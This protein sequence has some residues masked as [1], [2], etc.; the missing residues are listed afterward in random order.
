MLQIMLPYE[1]KVYTVTPDNP[2]ALSGEALCREAKRYHGSVTHTASV[3]KAVQLA[4]SEAAE[5]SGTMILA[6]G[7]L[8]WLGEMK[9]EMENRE[10]HD[11]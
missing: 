9:K 3:A 11:R 7:S 4:L 6:F 1:Y 8:S 2:R 10:D 5:A